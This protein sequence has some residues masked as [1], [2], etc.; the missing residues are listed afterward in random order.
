MS[1]IPREQLDALMPRV[2]D[3]LRK[4]ASRCMSGERAGHSLQT[5]ELVHETYVRLA[6]ITDLSWD[7][8]DHVLR[9][10]IAV[11]RRVLIDYARSHNAKKRDAGQLFLKA[12]NAGFAEAVE[13][14]VDIDMLSLDEALTRL[15][16][17]DARK[18]EIVE[19]RYFGGQDVPTVARLLGISPATVKRDWSLAKAWLYR[20][21]S[22]EEMT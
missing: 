18:A 15:A 7:D 1:Q 17:F 20:E 9:A 13:P 8:Q 3:E 16:E 19:L 4:Y 22:D 2:Y 21:L 5:T 11:M 6:K 12:P 10:A 14:E